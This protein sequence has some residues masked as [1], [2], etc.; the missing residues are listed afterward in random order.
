MR[1][2]RTAGYDTPESVAAELIYHISGNDLLLDRKEKLYS[3]LA[4][5]VAKGVYDTALAPKLMMRLVDAAATSYATEYGSM[6]GRDWKEMFPRDVRTIAA[7]MLVEEFE[8]TIEGASEEMLESVPK[9][10]RPGPPLRDR[11]TSR[12]V[13]RDPRHD[14]VTPRGASTHR[15]A[16]PQ[17][18]GDDPLSKLSSDIEV[19]EALGMD[20]VVKQ[21]KQ[22]LE[23]LK[24]QQKQGSARR[25]SSAFMEP[26]ITEDTFIVLDGPM[27]GTSFSADLVDMAE[28]EALQREIAEEG[29]AGL[30]GTSLADYTENEEVFEIEVKKGFSAYLSALGYM[31]RTED[32][33]FDTLEEAKDYLISE[34]PE[35][36]DVGATV[37]DLA[38]Q[39]G[40]ETGMEDYEIEEEMPEELF[41]LIAFGEADDDMIENWLRVKFEQGPVPPV[42][43]RGAS[44]HRASPTALAEERAYQLGQQYAQNNPPNLKAGDSEELYSAAMEMGC[45]RSLFDVFKY[46]AQDVW[47]KSG[48]LPQRQPARWNAYGSSKTPR[49]AST[50]RRPL[51]RR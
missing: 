48:Q 31:N 36:F 39:L 12:R 29:S 37:L 33:V 41:R 5:K 24:A 19:Y 49:G 27:G 30:S 34:Y 1:T 46:G 13:P 20:N 44:T 23:A 43:P 7:N 35:S 32:A 4:S 9:R 14:P 16:P 25:R 42:A 21:L 26:M 40:I 6:Q 8:Q 50:R 11:M 45:P 51:R 17:M 3:N 38:E 15:A 10:H 28:V 22:Q 18:T 2:N 47:R